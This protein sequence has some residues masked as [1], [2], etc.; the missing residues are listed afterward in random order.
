[1]A[2]PQCDG[3]SYFPFDV[4]FFS[5]RKIKI[6]R[7]SE[8]G[9]DAIIIYIYLLCE[10]YKGKGY[11]IAYDDDLVCCASADT[12]VPEGK[13]RQIVQLLA[14]KSLFDNTRFSAD[15][16][17]T[18]A[19]IQTRYQEAKKSTKRDVFVEPSVWILNEE[20]TLGFIKVH[21]KESFS[22]KNPTKEN[23]IKENKNKINKNKTATA[24]AVA[25][26]LE[27]VWQAFIEM[28]KKMRKPMTEYAMEI[29]I[30]KLETLA[31]GD[32]VTQ[33]KI[34]EQSVERSWQSVYELKEK[35]GVNNGRTEKPFKPSDW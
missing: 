34:L 28:R 2:R 1:M 15:N 27:P 7:G 30:K 12:G 29:T 4:D 20:A 26:E 10:I 24:I 14:S 21:P 3:L 11:Y 25:P 35:G 33:K 8:Y 6:I 31:P 18:A 32:T 17:L 5:D 16:L 23:K 22:E 9:T 19:S 13:T